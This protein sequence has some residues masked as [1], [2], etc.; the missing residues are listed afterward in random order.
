MLLSP[1]L[2]HTERVKEEGTKITSLY[3]IK[4]TIRLNNKANT[5]STMTGSDCDRMTSNNYI[6]PPQHSNSH[7]HYLKSTP[8]T[9]IGQNIGI[10]LRE[11]DSPNQNCSI[12]SC[13]LDRG[14]KQEVTLI[15]STEFANKRK[16]TWKLKISFLYSQ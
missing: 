14:Y 2:L 4:P 16:L 5:L 3:P 15:C 11:W 12:Y 13:L 10:F 8:V 7:F 1:R 6:I 9:S